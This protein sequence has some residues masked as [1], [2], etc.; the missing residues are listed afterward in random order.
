MYTIVKREI[1]CPPQRAYTVLEELRRGLE[2]PWAEAVDLDDGIKLI[3]SDRWVH[4][5]VSMT[6]PR[7]RVIA[8]ASAEGLA[9][10]LADDYVR[11]VERRM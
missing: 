10:D 7:I 2:V 11:L 1:V 6:E 4:I 3:G 5:R 8:E 9:M